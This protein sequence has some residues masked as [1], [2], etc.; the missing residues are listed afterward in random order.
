MK[1]PTLKMILQLGIPATMTALK[2]RRARKQTEHSDE[3]DVTIDCGE[4][5][6]DQLFKENKSQGL[7]GPGRV[8][9]PNHS[10]STQPEWKEPIQLDLF[11]DVT[12][13]GGMYKTPPKTTT[14]VDSLGSIRDMA[15]RMQAEHQTNNRRGDCLDR[16]KHDTTKLTPEQCAI[17]INRYVVYRVRH[18]EAGTKP[19]TE[20]RLCELLNEELGLD[21]SK[22]SY[23]RIYLTK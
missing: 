17:I 2:K 19:V 13:N 9:V 22:S 20:D 10:E 16:K 12:P 1:R 11:D 15:L 4:K 7:R 18:I 6:I 21:K 5:E 3:F 23:R 8:E 14:K